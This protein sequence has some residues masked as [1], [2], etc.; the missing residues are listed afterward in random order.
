[1]YRKTSVP[2]SYHPYLSTNTLDYEVLVFFII[3]VCGV[4]LAAPSGVSTLSG[5]NPYG[6]FFIKAINAKW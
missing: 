5:A 4:V 3:M 6:I 1:M 2:L